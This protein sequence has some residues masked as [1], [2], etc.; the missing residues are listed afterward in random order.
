MSTKADFLAEF[1]RGP[2]ARDEARVGLLRD[3]TQ[4][5]VDQLVVV[6]EESDQVEE[7]TVPH[8][9]DTPDLRDDNPDQAEP[10]ELHCREDGAK[11][12]AE[13]AREQVTDYILD[14][15]TFK[16]HLYPARV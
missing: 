9:E 3:L 8:V 11:D 10:P 16:I 7:E 13:A 2:E 12:V 5:P 6:D 14:G 1:L 4:L 15:V